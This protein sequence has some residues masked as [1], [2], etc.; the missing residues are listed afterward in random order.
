MELTR[1]EGP[2]TVCHCAGCHIEGIGGTE[3]Y[4]S[5]SSGC[6]VD[7]LDFY[8]DGCLEGIYCSTCAAKLVEVDPTRSV[9]Q[10]YS[11]TAGNEI[12]PRNL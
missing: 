11:D 6:L 9:S 2:A 8:V 12:H 5:A 1:I 10:F 7:P 3:P 4:L